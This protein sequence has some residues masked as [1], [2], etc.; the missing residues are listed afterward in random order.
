MTK[1]S[2]HGIIK[3]I[4]DASKEAALLGS[5]K[6][7]LHVTGASFIRG[8]TLMLL[9]ALDSKD[10]TISNMKEMTLKVGMITNDDGSYECRLFVKG[11][12][13]SKGWGKTEAEALFNAAEYHLAKE[14]RKDG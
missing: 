6:V 4:D 12:A 8:T 7:V 5:D 1:N 10:V 2:D 3:L 11:N 9:D 14:R 13:E